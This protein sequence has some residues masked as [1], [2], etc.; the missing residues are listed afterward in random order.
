VNYTSLSTTDQV[1]SQ[2]PADF[3]N[4]AEA[5]VKAVVHVKTQ[6]Q[7]RTVTAQDPFFNDDFF[8][9]LF[10]QRQYYIPPQ[11]GS[12]SGVVISPDGYIV[13][14]YHVISNAALVTVTFNDRFTTQAEVVAK[15]A[16]TDIALLK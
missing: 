3:E 15:D 6:T 10:G 8:G 5:S 16:S 14:N 9:G 1:K 4:A 12:G 7:G 11:R 2:P 13:T